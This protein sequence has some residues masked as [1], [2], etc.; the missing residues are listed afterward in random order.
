MELAIL[1][2]VGVFLLFAFVVFYGAPYLP[3]LKPQIDAAFELLK[4]KP[5]KTLL[6]LGSGDGK[7][8][9]AAAQAGYCAVGIELNPILVLISLWRT[10]KHRKQVK[11]IWGNFWRVAWPQADAVFVFL[12][13]RYMPK[14]DE[15]MHTYG[16][17]LA[18]VAFK[19]PHQQIANEKQGVYLYYYKQSHKY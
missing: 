6:E 18:S 2:G 13:D 8:L 17:P 1:L 15:Q 10:R 5:G 12:L 16:G 3:T 7:V 11:V 4:L 9:L 14:L 19:V